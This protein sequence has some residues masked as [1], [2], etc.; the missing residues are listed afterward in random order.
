[1][2]PNRVHSQASPLACLLPTERRL[3][4]IRATASHRNQFHLLS[5]EN[6]AKS[7]AIVMSA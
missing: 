6:I 2:A 1:M 4:I 3:E 7:S 5:R